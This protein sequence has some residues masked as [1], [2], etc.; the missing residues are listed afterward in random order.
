[1]EFIEKESDRFVYTGSMQ[2]LAGVKCCTNRRITNHP[3]FED[4]RLRDRTFRLYQVYGRQPVEDVIRM[5]KAEKA[6][7]VIV[8]N[9]I[10][11]AKSDGCTL[12]DVVDVANGVRTESDRLPPGVQPAHLQPADRPRWCEVV[13]KAENAAVAQSLRLVFQNRTFRVYRLL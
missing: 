8:E 4:K 3:H 9:S 12:K 13:E 5:L 7:H 1:M 6:T 2:L 11:Y 10:C